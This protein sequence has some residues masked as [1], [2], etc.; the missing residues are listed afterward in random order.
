MMCT[1]SQKRE[2]NDW[3]YTVCDK[4]FS[5]LKNRAT[6]DGVRKYLHRLW[7]ISEKEL[8]ILFIRWWVRVF[9]NIWCC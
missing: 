1:L 4:L 3:N 5:R 8:I 2:S 7:Q 6:V 9:S